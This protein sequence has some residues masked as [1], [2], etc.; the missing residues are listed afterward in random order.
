MISVRPI[1]SYVYFVGI[2]QC[3]EQNMNIH[4]CD[5]KL[6]L[7]CLQSLHALCLYKPMFIFLVTENR[8]MR[9]SFVK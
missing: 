7:Q 2:S 4:H 8:E 9:L 5:L 3:Y 6:E 1:A